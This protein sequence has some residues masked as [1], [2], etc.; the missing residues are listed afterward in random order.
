MHTQ[1]HIVASTT[2]KTTYKY[3]LFLFSSSFSY[4]DA[5][6]GCALARATLY[7]MC[8]SVVTVVCVCVCTERAVFGLDIKHDYS[9]TAFSYYSDAAEKSSEYQWS[10]SPTTS[11]QPQCEPRA[12]TCSHRNIHLF[13]GT[14]RTL[15]S[16]SVTA[17]ACPLVHENGM[18]WILMPWGIAHQLQV[19]FPPT[20]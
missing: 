16:E 8:K 2:N 18:R 4:F 15:S 5:S 20:W 1:I 17:D 11:H 12:I 13:E 6:L 19:Y 7:D 14:E 3:V 10:Q 9:L